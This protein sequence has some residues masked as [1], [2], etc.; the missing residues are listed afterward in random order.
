[1]SASGYLPMNV[2]AQRLHV[3][4][5]TLRNWFDRKIIRGF[6]LPTGARRIPESEVERLERERF[7]PPSSFAPSEVNA[8]PKVSRHEVP[9]A[10]CHDL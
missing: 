3:W 5:S 1:M 9:Q 4:E 2:A 10:S 8:S 7:G 6:R